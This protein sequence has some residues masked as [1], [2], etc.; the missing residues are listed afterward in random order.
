[1][2]SQRTITTPNYREKKGV[3]AMKK[4]ELEKSDFLGLPAAAYFRAPR[5]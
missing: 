3:G 2:I 5:I 1:M 4:G